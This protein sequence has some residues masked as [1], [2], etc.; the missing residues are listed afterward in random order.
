M[1]YCFYVLLLC[2]TSTAAWSQFS[3]GVLGGTD[4]DTVNNVDAS[5]AA[6]D[7][8][9]N[10]YVSRS[11]H[12]IGGFV[13]Y[14]FPKWFVRTELMQLKRNHTF[15]IPIVLTDVKR[16]ITDFEV[17]QLDIPLLVGYA[18]TSDLR[19]FA[20]PNWTINQRATMKETSISDLSKHVI[21]GAQFGLGYQYK[22]FEL[23]MRYALNGQTHEV[24]F[25]SSPIGQKNQYIQSQGQ[26]VML[27]IA[28]YLL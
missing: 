3:I 7:K 19:V 22:R 15:K 14:S 28:A 2:F 6:L 23:D 18:L 1:R 10:I 11:G 5:V 20:G 16:I 17:T 8:N 24:N 9:I 4:F 26:F 12:H 27:S 13:K 21:T 25:L